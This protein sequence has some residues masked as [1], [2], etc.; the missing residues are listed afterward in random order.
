MKKSSIGEDSSPELI[1]E[2]L[3]KIAGRTH[4]L[5][6]LEAQVHIINFWWIQGNFS[7]IIFYFFLKV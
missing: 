3:M 7:Q 2:S 1:A 5:A 6:A 4:Q